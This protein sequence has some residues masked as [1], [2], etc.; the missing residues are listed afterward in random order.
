MQNPLVLDLTP[1]DAFAK[2]LPV[3][4]RTY[5]FNKLGYEEIRKRE[6]TDN[7]CQLSNQLLYL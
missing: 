5:P 4:S 2:Q 1:T 3:A 7:A 6:D